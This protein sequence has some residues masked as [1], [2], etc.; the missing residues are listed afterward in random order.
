M[1]GD[2]TVDALLALRAAGPRSFEDLI[3]ELLGDLTGQ[4]YRLSASGRQDGVDGIAASGSIGFQAKRYEDKSLD[5]SS[6]IGDMNRAARAWPDLELWVLVTTRRLL[7]KDRQE[8]SEAAAEHGLAFLPLAAGDAQAP[9]HPVAGLC[10]LLAERTCEVLQD[11]GWQDRAEFGTHFDQAQAVRR[12]VQ[13]ELDRWL[14]AAQST[15]VPRQ[16]RQ[17]RKSALSRALAETASA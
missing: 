4:T 14:A 17:A 12:T 9:F 6:L 15:P 11:P 3:G 10:A 13:P 7:P 1:L 8:L 2:K 5:L 16:P